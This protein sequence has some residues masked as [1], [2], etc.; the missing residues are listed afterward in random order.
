M[1][2][3]VNV[4]FVIFKT[5]Q[6]SKE[7]MWTRSLYN[8][9]ESHLKSIW[10]WNH[11]NSHFSFREIMSWWILMILWSLCCH[12]ARPTNVTSIEFEIWSKFWVLWF[13]VCSTNHK[14]ILYMSR[15]WNCR[16]I[17]TISLWSAEYVMNKSITKFQWI[18]ILIEMI[19]HATGAWYVQKFVAISSFMILQY[20][21]CESRDWDLEHSHCCEIC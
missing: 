15:Q 13:K 4:Y 7:L 18:S 21:S 2:Q 12:D 8:M 20:E 1:I 19:I 16:D 10:H 3:N 5:I 11:V 9:E 6:H 14:E 17:C